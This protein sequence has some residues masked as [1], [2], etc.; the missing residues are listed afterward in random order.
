MN[1]SKAAVVASAVLGKAASIIG[2]ILGPIT[3]PIIMFG[4]SDM[5]SPGAVPAMTF[6]VIL[7]ALSVFSIIKGSQIKRRIRR[8]KR[9]VSLISAQHMTSLDA[10]AMSTSQSVDFVRADLQKMISKRFFANAAINTATGQIVIGGMPPAPP[11]TYA[12]RPAQ[13][14]AQAEMVTYTCSG[15]GA[16]GAK[17][18]SAV[19]N[20]EYCGSL[21]Q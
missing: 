19:V 20:C 6:L 12:P 10:I 14:A 9:Y 4:L 8:F 13:T 18:K 21:I 3:L 11:P 16:S 17:P 5:D 1:T 15:C 7:L 2:Y